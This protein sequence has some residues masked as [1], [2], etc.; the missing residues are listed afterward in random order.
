MAQIP[1]VVQVQ[2][3][4]WKLQHAMSTA[5]KEKK[6]KKRLPDLMLMFT[7]HSKLVSEFK[8]SFCLCAVH[9]LGTTF[10]CH[11]LLTIRQGGT[12]PVSVMVKLATSVLLIP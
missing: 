10:P 5:Q 12:E 3:L 11:G 2:S 6:K 7:Q 1:A 4:A 8:A 9:M